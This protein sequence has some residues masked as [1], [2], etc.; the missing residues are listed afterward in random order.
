MKPTISLCMI[1]KNEEAQL[2]RCLSSVA[3]VVDEMVVVDTGST[4]ATIAI[5]ESFGA[6]IY[7]HAWDGSFSSAR[8]V[9]LSYATGEWVLVLDADEALAAGVP[10]RELLAAAAEDREAFIL[11]L[12]NFVGERANEEAV[13]APSVRLFR[14][15]PEYRY[16]RALHEQIMLA[17]QATRPESVAGYLDA[18]IE[19]FGYL[20]NVVAGKDKIQRNL[21]LAQEEVKRYPDDAF[22][23]YNLGQEHF[24][25][26]EWDDAVR[27]Y[28]RGFPY[29]Q[30]LMA[31]FAPALVKH[32]TV[33]LLNLNRSDEALAVTKDAQ[34]AYEQFTDLWILQGV[35]YMQKNDYAAAAERFREALA[36]GEVAGGFYISDEGVGTYKAQWWLANCLLQL[37]RHDEALA[38]LVASQAEMQ[39]RRRYL[40][41]AL[42]GMMQIMLWRN[43]PE[44]EVVGWLGQYVD[45]SDPRWCQLVGRLL[46]QKG[47]E[48][49]GFEALNRAGDWDPATLLAAGVVHLRHGDAERALA[50]WEAVPRES[51]EWLTAQWHLLLG[52]A[53]RSEWGL[54]EA[55]LEN[56][57]APLGESELV[58]IY[59]GLVCLWRGD[60]DVAAPRLQRG[61]EAAQAHLAGVLELFLA[62]GAHTAF[63][64]S[65]PA[66]EWVG[67]PPV[68]QAALLGGLYHQAGYHD[69]AFEALLLAFE[70]GDRTTETVR[71]LGLSCLRRGAYAEAEELLREVLRQ[72]GEQGVPLSAQNSALLGYLAAL[73][74]QG[75]DSEAEPLWRSVLTGEITTEM[76]QRRVA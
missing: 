36:K 48:Q 54:A 20:N 71:L 47:L 45:L 63:Q 19:H 16:T 56:Q 10:L 2:A 6:R 53:A 35:A 44:A 62:A 60:S 52:H 4:D 75:R 29:L 46:L 72:Q 5:A 30:S 15:R 12:V 28:Q 70:G 59:R 68:K 22:S 38:A 21:A 7:H 32:L 67:M 43:L 13:T 33:C 64:Q 74:A 3:G 17:I 69:M 34:E 9:S 65:L 61:H 42:E 39:R 76:T 23:W 66:L 51:C 8:N 11:P 26:A 40:P 73:S 55:R 58:E 37:G 31:G 24:R 41:Q 18:P 57:I 27:A 50:C 49:A 25:L 14:N 1:V